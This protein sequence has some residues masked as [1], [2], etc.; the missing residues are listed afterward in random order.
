MH[1]QLYIPKKIKV[2][3]VKRSDTFTGNLG[4]VIYYNDKGELK[5]E[6]SWDGWRDK[7]IAPKEFDN[8]PRSNFIFNK[9]VKRYGHWS[10][11]SK[12]RIYDSRDFEFEIDFSNMMYILMHSDVSKRD[13]QEECVFA[14]SGKNLVLIPVNSQEYIESMEYTQKQGMSFSF[15]DLVE[16]HTYST[17]KAGDYIYLGHFDWATKSYGSSQY[18]SEGKKHIFYNVVKPGY[19]DRYTILEAKDIAA[20]ISNEV[21]SDYA[22]IVENLMKTPNTKKVGVFSIKKGFNTVGYKK[23]SGESVK[24]F[25]NE[26]NNSFDVSPIKFEESQGIPRVIAVSKKNHYSYD[27]VSSL[28]KEYLYRMK[29]EG[30]DSTDIKAVKQYFLN[31]GFGQVIYTDPNKV[32]TVV[33][34]E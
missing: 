31:T 12:V 33:T 22:I 17:K 16:G 1:T 28:K 21:A 9:D 26:A 6:K 14:W 7:S 5:Q 18:V 34:V 3:F 32:K 10:S 4:F 24:V 20:C 23:F 30:I 27:G 13:I 19:G 8:V 29:K 2:G 15:K 25:I 11:N